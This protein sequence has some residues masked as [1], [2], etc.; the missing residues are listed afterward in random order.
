[1]NNLSPTLVTGGTGMSLTLDRATKRDL[2]LSI[3]LEE[4]VEVLVSYMDS[5]N[6][7][8]LSMMERFQNRDTIGL[9]FLALLRPDDAYGRG[10]DYLDAVRRMARTTNKTTA[11]TTLREAYTIVCAESSIQSVTI[12]RGF[13][14]VWEKHK[15]DIL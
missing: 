9:K 1:M 15:N 11:L 12:K 2:A 4:A 3:F 5:E 6:G 10:L 7:H 8:D 14:K 13:D